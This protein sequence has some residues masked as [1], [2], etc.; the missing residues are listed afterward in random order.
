[1]IYLWETHA[2]LDFIVCSPSSLINFSSKNR[3]GLACYL[4]CEERISNG[5]D[6]FFLMKRTLFS[7]LSSY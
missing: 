4:I 6:R 1:M 7:V 3:S 2:A 5:M